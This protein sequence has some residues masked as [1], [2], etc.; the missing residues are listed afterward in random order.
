[1]RILL[2]GPKFYHY[3]SSIIQ[4]FVD[5]GF[6]THLFEY[7]EPID[8]NTIVRKGLSLIFRRSYKRIN[9]R[10]LSRMFLIEFNIFKPDLVLVIKGNLLTREALEYI[11]KRSKLFLWMMDSIVYYPDSEKLADIYDHVFCFEKSDIEVLAKKNIPATFLPL[12]VDESIFNMEQE[13][14]KDIDV[15]FVGSLYK[16][17]L[18]FFENFIK[19]SPNVNIRVYGPSEG[20]M[21]KLRLLLGLKS[22]DEKICI[23]K[24]NASE[25]VK[26]YHRSKI[27]INI[28]HEQ[29]K[30]GVNP[31]FFEII[32]TGAFQIV[33]QKPFIEEYFRNYHIAQFSNFA[34]LEELILLTLNSTAW[35]TVD[36]LLINDVINN[37]TFRNRIE[38]ILSFWEKGELI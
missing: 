14:T 29:S 22:V 16:D 15:L 11:G 38:C 4:A 37:H 31:R 10:S 8:P 30:Y 2:I 23:K 3:N 12:A 17:R 32:A 19:N 28:H 21:L 35:K 36:T 27:V 9:N 26:L 34:Q 13:V 20:K 1:M 6:Q 24:V 18:S 25:L 33:D 7:T 5:K